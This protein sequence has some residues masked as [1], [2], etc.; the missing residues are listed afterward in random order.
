MISPYRLGLR[1]LRSSAQHNPHAPHHIVSPLSLLFALG[2]LSET[3][4]TGRELNRLLELLHCRTTTEV[5]EKL[6][7]LASA[8]TPH[9]GVH[10]ATHLAIK[11]PLPTYPECLEQL[12]LYPHTDAK[13][14]DATNYQELNAWVSKNTGG[15]ITSAGVDFSETDLAILSALY[16]KAAWRHN[17][18][19]SA[20]RYRPFYSHGETHHVP[21]MASHNDLRYLHFEGWEAVR[22]PY[23]RRGLSAA[24]LLPPTGTSPW[25]ITPE[26][27]SE[28]LG[29]LRHVPYRDME[30]VIPKLDVELDIELPI[31]SLGL[32]LRNCF[33]R[34]SP[35]PL[36]LGK[37]GQKVRL[38]VDEEGTEGA[39]LTYFFINIIGAPQEPPPP[40][41]VLVFDRP[42]LMVIYED[43][44]LVPIFLSAIEMP[45]GGRIKKEKAQDVPEGKL[46]PVNYGPTELEGYYTDYEEWRRDHP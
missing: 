26:H 13:S 18:E 14:Y 25:E 9:K 19:Y 11:A 5:R 41:P 42:Y 35:Q 17:F 43:S 39:A 1:T 20:S 12:S 7:T 37:A 34:L 3:L 8:L 36:E 23:R 2:A 27:L 15:L 45:T 6:D 29:K 38:K 46:V 32:D 30:V 28:A 40:P 22:L 31:C 21:M 16:F 33:Q 44:I 4:G 10:Y 24:F